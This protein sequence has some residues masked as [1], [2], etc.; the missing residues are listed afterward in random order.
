MIKHT[1]ARITRTIDKNQPSEVLEKTHNQMEYYMG[2]KLVE[3]GVNPKSAI[4]RWSVSNQNNEKLWT[5]TAYWGS[6]KEKLLSGKMPLIG[7]DL[8]E[9]AKANASSGLETTA[10]LCGYGSDVTGFQ[11][12]VQQAG[13]QLGL[14]IKSLNDLIESQ[15]NRG[16]DFA[17]DNNS[18]L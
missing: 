15:S 13:S 4:Y 3:I 16:L 9:C 12:A 7:I 18:S 5:L 6:D 1:R 11:S 10:I 17:P 14:N 2:A 8:I